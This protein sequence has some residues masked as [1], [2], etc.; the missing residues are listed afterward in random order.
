MKLVTDQ[1][2]KVKKQYF[3]ILFLV[4]KGT[5]NVLDLSEA[6]KRDAFLKTLSVELESFYKDR[7]TIY[8]TFCDKKEDGT[9]D[10]IDN[11]YRFDP[12]KL[13]DINKELKALYE[14][15]VSFDLPI[16]GILEKSEYKPK[17]GEA[18]VIDSLITLCEN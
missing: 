15:E 18:E 11:Q 7:T 10:I 17:V 12:I 6:R 8:E 9:P 14:E 5:E 16:K 3:D 1:I 4:L 2:M 13:D